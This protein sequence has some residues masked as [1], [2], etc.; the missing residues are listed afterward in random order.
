MP[1]KRTMKRT[2]KKTTST[3]VPQNNTKLC[4]GCEGSI[5]QDEVLTCS[6]CQLSLHR[7]CAGIPRTHYADISLQFVC[8]ACAQKASDTTICELKNEV[9]ALKAEVLLL[10]SAISERNAATT[11]Q[12]S[13]KPINVGPRWTEVVRRGKN[14]NT[15]RTNPPRRTRPE[16]QDH[17]TTTTQVNQPNRAR[18]MV[19]GVRRVWGTKKDASTTVVLHTISQLTKLDPEKRL[20]VKRKFQEGES[21]RR[22]RWWFLL[23][24]SEAILC[25]LESLWSCV[26]LQ[27]GWKLEACT[28]PSNIENKENVGTT[29]NNSEHAKSNKVE[30]QDVLNDSSNSPASTNAISPELSVIQQSDKNTGNT[31]VNN[32]SSSQSVPHHS[33][34]NPSSTDTSKDSVFLD[35]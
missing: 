31:D 9:A 22:D 26:S 35:N 29:T 13:S 25:E 15:G 32:T 20:T 8:L 3:D 27:V 11:E 19:P 16:S 18:V 17:A 28:K 30:A 12:G 24:S 33:H 7:Y 6:S 34:H 4:D 10:K 5:P 2:T 1:P 23:R 21:G 14:T